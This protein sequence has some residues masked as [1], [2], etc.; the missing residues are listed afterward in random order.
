[1]LETYHDIYMEDTS[2]KEGPINLSEDDIR[3]MISQLREN[4]GSPLTN[5]LRENLQ[6]LMKLGKLENM[7][8]TPEDL[9][10]INYT[11]SNRSNI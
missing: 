6:E 2:S 8:L 3:K 7:E 10:I 5:D 11:P 9:K 1:V 4:P